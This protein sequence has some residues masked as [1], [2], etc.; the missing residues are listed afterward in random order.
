MALAGHPELVFFDEITTGLDPQ[1]RRAT[2][3]LVRRVR[4]AGVTVV[5]VSH[6]MDEVAAL[7]DRVAILD[8]GR[9]VA[10]DTPRGLVERT[11]AGSFED[12]YLALVDED[13]EVT[14]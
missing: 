14:S 8:G 6:L 3:K 9:V 13:T 11:G 7:A 5:L 2:W 4:D 1:A 10:E 12:A